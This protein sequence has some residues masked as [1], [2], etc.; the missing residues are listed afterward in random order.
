MVDNS[1]GVKLFV[2]CVP[3]LLC[4]GC[5]T[6]RSIGTRLSL[7][8]DFSNGVPFGKLRA[9]S[10]LRKPPL[11]MTRL[12]VDSFQTIRRTYDELSMCA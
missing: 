4:A 10:R 1:R 2:R 7:F 5:K 11:E 3:L 8:G 12:E 6:R 9:G